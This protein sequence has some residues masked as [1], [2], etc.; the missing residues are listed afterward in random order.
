MGVGIIRFIRVMRAVAVCAVLLVAAA[1]GSGAALSQAAPGDGGRLAD[2]PT[3][4]LAALGG[5]PDVAL[6]G[7][8]GTATLTVP[9]PTGLTPAALTANVELPANVRGGNVIATQHGRTLS[10]VELLQADDTPITIP[11]SGARIDDGML[12]F[13]LRSRLLPAPG[14][15]LYDP[16]I[17]LRLTDAAIAFAGRE[18]PPTLVADFLPSVLQ[19]LTIFVP[20]SPSRAESAAAL[21]LTTAV[22]HRYGA[23]N[24]D[25]AIA[26]LV[27]DEAVP[28]SSELER[29]VVIRE[30]A[31]AGVALSGGDGVPTLNITGSGDE[32]VDQAR[33]LTSKLSNLALS[34][35]AVAGE[36][37]STTPA[38]ENPTTIGDLG[39]S[40]ATAVAFNPQ[41]FVRVDQTRLGKPVRNVRVHLKG[42]HTPLPP[43]VGGQVIASVG[44]QT[45]DR[46]A[47]DSSG[48]IDRTV[49]IPDSVLKRS[50]ELRVAVDIAGETG[51][52]GEFEPIT[53]RIDDSTSI[54]SEPGN[55]PAA[56]GFQSLPQALMPTVKVG[57][58][59]D[60]FTDT[61]RAATILEGLQ[62]LSGLP[63]DP[64]LVSLPDAIDSHSP[65][66]LVSAGGWH[67]QKVAPP[68][69]TTEDGRV[70]DALR[71]ESPPHFGSLQ[72][73]RDKNRTVVIATSDGAPELLDSLLAWLDSHPARW[74]SLDGIAVLAPPGRE[75][76]V[77]EAD[78]AEQYSVPA[79]RG[80][81]A[82]VWVAAGAVGLLGL[83]VAGGLLYR[84]RH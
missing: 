72:T 16:A 35:K 11:L 67:D 76:V 82:P 78:V 43:S 7:L 57:I 12:T 44:D 65:A 50:T 73:V 4:N 21:E 8:Q 33:L 27:P 2:R 40:G 84:R 1:L 48:D 80:S 54:E 63:L 24:T 32:L 55:S 42:S 36:I 58:G 41:A 52:C 17:P 81:G 45:I 59:Q 6:Y 23:Q 38:P 29:N 30:D 56:V 19:R 62:R 71:L 15:C 14:E 39:Q 77:V 74:S 5:G 9:V 70:S 31:D 64:E 75:P 13:Q 60:A 69:R 61:V 3:L 18:K 47:V 34:P 53:L 10:R 49:A 25:V 22:V 28:A 83:A 26:P 20:R 46:W 68:V 37:E 79:E 66:I 51:R